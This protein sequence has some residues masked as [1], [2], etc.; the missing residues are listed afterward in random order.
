MSKESTRLAHYVLTDPARA[1]SMAEQIL[2]RRRT[3]R[4]LKPKS[5]RPSAVAARVKREERRERS[6][7]IRTAVMIRANGRCESCGDR[8][9]PTMLHWH[10]TIQGV[11]RRRQSESTSTT[12]AVCA[13]C[14]AS[15]HDNAA[16]RDRLRS[17]AAHLGATP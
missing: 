3:S 13:R 9:D 10:H 6:A 5:R 14:H 15:A 16:S 4:L 17:I 7:L 2:Q 1:Q 12:L 8:V 11:G